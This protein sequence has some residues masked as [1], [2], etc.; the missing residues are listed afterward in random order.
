[1][2]SVNPPEVD[3]SL[4]QRPDKAELKVAHKGGAYGVSESRLIFQPLRRRTPAQCYK[5]S[6]AILVH[7]N[8]GVQKTKYRRKTS[9]SDGGKNAA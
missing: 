7:R 4:R 9:R 6:K 8:N 5:Y 3:I 2:F 1:M